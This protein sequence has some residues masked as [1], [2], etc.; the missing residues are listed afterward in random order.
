MRA[1][2]QILQD[3][4]ADREAA[5]GATQGTYS[6]WAQQPSVNVMNADGK[7]IAFMDTWD[8]KGCFD[9]ENF[10]R[11]ASPSRVAQ[12]ATDIAD[13]SDLL[14]RMAVELA[15][16]ISYTP[17]YFRDKHGIGEVL[18]EYAALSAHEAVRK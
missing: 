18:A 4:A 8:G 9:A 11:N 12:R 6:V 17:E 16:A 7:T 10:T 2:S 14:A 3:S 13:L 5:E 15:E 1:L